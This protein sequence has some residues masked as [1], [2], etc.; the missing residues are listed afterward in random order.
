MTPLEMAKGVL[1]QGA[2]AP[3]VTLAV[4]LIE[5]EQ[6]L[7]QSQAALRAEHARCVAVVHGVAQKHRKADGTRTVEGYGALDAWDVLSTAR[8]DMTGTDRAALDAVLDAALV[9]ARE[10]MRDAAV[11]VCHA[12]WESYATQ[13]DPAMQA[14][15]TECAHAISA[16]PLTGGAK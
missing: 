16:L 11:M 4:A 7:A 14:A 13:N 9:R 8:P 15:A 2:D 5:S 3:T 6:R 12:R 10:E 1:E